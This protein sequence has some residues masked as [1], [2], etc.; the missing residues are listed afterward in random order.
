MSKDDLKRDLL[1][2]GN[3]KEIMKEF[4]SSNIHK[5]SLK[6]DNVE[7]SLEKEEVVYAQAPSHPVMPAMQM[8]APHVVGGETA[9]VNAE[10]SDTFDGE[11]VKAPLVGTYY[12]APSPD[13]APF[14]KVG[15]KVS[16]GQ[17]ILII[18]AMKVMNEIT[19]TCAGTVTEILV[20]N[21]ELVEYDQPLVVIK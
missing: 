4:D 20:S 17:T 5:L 16:E 18:E 2:L 21:Q 14:I 1:D 11:V 10:T 3:I 19:A 6:V 9:V 15:D 12:S 8:H 7:V 13:S